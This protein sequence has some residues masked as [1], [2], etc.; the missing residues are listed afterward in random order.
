M[1]VSKL[2]LK[3]R[4]SAQRYLRDRVVIDPVSSCWN[5]QQSMNNKGYGLARV[6][7]MR[8]VTLTVHR[9]AYMAFIGEIPENLLVCHTCDNR[10]CCNPAHLFVGTVSDNWADRIQK[11]E[12]E[13]VYAI[14]TLRAMRKG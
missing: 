13:G 9:M 7:G 14:H 5:W 8:E 4:Q 12:S 11:R 10:R 1:G 6:P 3:I 2:P